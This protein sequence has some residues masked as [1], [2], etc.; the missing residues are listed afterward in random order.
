MENKKSAYILILTTEEYLTGLKITYN[1][2][3]EF[4]NM[5]VVVLINEEITDVVELELTNLGMRT[6]RVDNIAL[7]PDVLSEKMQRDRWYHTLFKL[8]VFGMTE[9]DSLIYLDS[10]LLICGQLDELF[11]RESLT[12]VS[13]ADFFPEYSRGGI[14]AGVFA[15]RPSKKLEQSL[16]DMIPKVAAEMEI[17]GD[18]DV[19]NTYFDSWEKKQKII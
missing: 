6:I 15:F 17:F 2:L 18:Q 14:N 11:W 13:D 10:D 7:E 12:A 4:T 9:Y 1:S 3:R 16:I 8:R 5:E 19:I